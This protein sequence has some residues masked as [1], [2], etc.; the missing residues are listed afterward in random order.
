MI[1][2]TYICS[3]SRGVEYGFTFKEH[4]GV[5]DTLFDL[6]IGISCPGRTLAADMTADWGRLE[7]AAKAIV[8]AFKEPA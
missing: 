6:V 4:C 8:E 2:E 3:T 1:Y 5:D 7:W